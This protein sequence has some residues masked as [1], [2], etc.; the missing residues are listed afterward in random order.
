MAENVR[1]LTAE[2]EIVKIDAMGK[3]VRLTTDPSSELLP[4]PDSMLPPKVASPKPINEPSPRIKSEAPPAKKQTPK[5]I[6][7]PPK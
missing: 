5:R 3:S 7:E 4:V 2:I 6:E 1:T